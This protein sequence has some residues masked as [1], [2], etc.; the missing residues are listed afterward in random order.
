MNG[1]LLGMFKFIMGD[2]EFESLTF[3][4]LFVTLGNSTLVIILS[5]FI[6]Q[7]ILRILLD[8]EKGSRR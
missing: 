7:W 6:C 3:G 4:S 5:F 8:L 2:A 1:S